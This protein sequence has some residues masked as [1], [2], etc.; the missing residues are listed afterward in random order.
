MAPFS[1]IHLKVV[2][3]AVAGRPERTKVSVSVDVPLAPGRTTTLD[4]R[5]PAVGLEDL[6]R[7]VGEHE[8]SR[9]QRPRDERRGDHVAVGRLDI[10]KPVHEPHPTI[11]AAS[12]R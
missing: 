1:T 8:L 12:A 5:G 11:V 6:G 4:V 3:G 9:R 7:T 10:I 2:T